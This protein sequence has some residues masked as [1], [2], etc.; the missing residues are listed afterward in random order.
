MNDAVVNRGF[1][2]ARLDL[3]QRFETF[4]TMARKT[5]L[6]YSRYPIAFAALFAQ[7]FL[8]ILLFV[9]TTVAF[10]GGDPVRIST[11]AGA[12]AYGFVVNI[13]LSFTLWEI[14]FSIREEQV[15]GTLESLYL[16]PANK[17]SNLVSRIFAVLS[18]TIVM[19][20]G[21][22]AL[23]SAVAGGL[24]AH[25][26]GKGLLALLL[27]TSGFLGL[28]FIFAGVTIKLKETAQLLVNG[29]Q[30]F[31]MI[32]SAMFFPFSALRNVSPAIVDYI[33]AMLP[34]SYCVDLFRSTLLGT[35]PELA[36]WNVEWVIVLAFG[37]L[38]PLIGY[39]VYDR[40]ERKARMEGSLGEY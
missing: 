4:A 33:S 1:G 9:L 34:V 5:L 40:I 3:R 6:E 20:L 8:I 2:L 17:F 16:S 21:G 12:M 18:I 10:A 29:L 25:N 13:I 37:L 11:F 38:S 15:R 23:V 24:P 19:C 35:P 36:P 7:I 30:F 22:L 32:F 31:F 26:V 28:G 27:T 39:L 14:G